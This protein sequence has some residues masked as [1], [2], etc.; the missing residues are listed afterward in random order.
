MSRHAFFLPREVEYAWKTFGIHSDELELF[1]LDNCTPIQTTGCWEWNGLRVG[2]GNDA[3]LSEKYGA[4]DWLFEDGT[5]KR[6]Y[7]HRVSQQ[8]W[9]GPLTRAKPWALHSC[10]NPPCC[11]PDHLRAGNPYENTHDSISRGRREH[12]HAAARAHATERAKIAA[13][14]R[15]QGLTQKAIADILGTTQPC[16]SVLLKKHGKAA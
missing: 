10:D 7:A 3:P 16:V 4:F 15:A 5:R 2:G 1:M 9:N 14:L 8:L 12:I 6:F 13:D 11:N